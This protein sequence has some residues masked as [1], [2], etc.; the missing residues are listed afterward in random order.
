MKKVI[1][2]VCCAL[3]LSISGRPAVADDLANQC[4]ATCADNEG[5]CFSSISF[6]SNDADGQSDPRYEDAYVACQSARASC[7]KTCTEQEQERMEW[8]K[9]RNE[10][11]KAPGEPAAPAPAAGNAPPE[12]AAPPADTQPPV[13][14]QD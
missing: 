10:P 2:A 6:S 1:L 9:K 7:Q 3:L 12:A 5:F 8:E 13:P 11:E 4:M 14:P